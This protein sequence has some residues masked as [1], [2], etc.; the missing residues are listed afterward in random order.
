M[1]EE[2]EVQIK[3]PDGT[4]RTYIISKFP[5]VAGREIIAKYPLSGMPKLG[6]YNVNEETMLKLMC[7]VQSVSDAGVNT[8]LKTKALVDNHVPDWETLAHIEIEMMGYNCS[9][10][11]NGKI[12]SFFDNIKVNAEQSI[13][14]ILTV[15]L[16]RLS[17]AEK[18]PSTNS[19]Q[20]TH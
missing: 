4:E 12:S 10:F 5:A 13:M 17:P 11:G 16:E 19:K 1:L 2:K 9:F 15:L 3:L 18:Q 6:D 14:S 20:D 8:A 7:Y